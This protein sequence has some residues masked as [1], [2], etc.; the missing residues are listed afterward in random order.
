MLAA[1]PSLVLGCRLRVF[2][3][4]IDG[5]YKGPRNRTKKAVMSRML[6]ADFKMR[7][8]RTRGG[9][10]EVSDI[11]TVANVHMHS[12]TAKQETY[13]KKEVYDVFWDWLAQ[14]IIHFGVRIMGGD[15]NMSL[16]CVIPQLRARGFQ[17]NLA[18]FYPFWMEAHREMF[19]D[20]CGV[21]LIG[22]WQG[23]R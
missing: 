12:M 8:F 16:V 15:F 17:I 6:V 10:G 11:L 3:R 7:N 5:Y 20:S 4:R 1:K 22:P 9:G 13:D 2:H 19:T 14:Y 18:A 23:V 21:F